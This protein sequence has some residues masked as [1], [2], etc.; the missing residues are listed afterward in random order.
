MRKTPQKNDYTNNYIIYILP[1]ISIY[2]KNFYTEII[3][4]FYLLH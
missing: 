4:L 2:T 1:K 3:A